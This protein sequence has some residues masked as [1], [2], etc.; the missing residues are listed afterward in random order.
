MNKKSIC[1]KFRII[2][3]NYMDN[4]LSADEARAVK[5]HLESCTECAREL[6]IRREIDAIGK[7]HVFSDPGKTFWSDQRKQISAA[8]AGEDDP[9]SSHG[10]N[11]GRRARTLFGSFGRRT[12][13]G[14]AA[15][16]ILILVITN[17]VYRDEPSYQREQPILQ[18]KPELN[19]NVVMPELSERPK[20]ASQ[21][22]E[23][24]QTV[25]QP[26]PS[27]AKV[28]QLQQEERQAMV[29]IKTKS[30][31]GVQR[32]TAGEPAARQKEI[33]AGERPLKTQQA[34]QSSGEHRQTRTFTV[35]E[36]RQSPLQ[37]PTI[38]SESAKLNM[39][40]ALKLPQT[41]NIAE[42][43]DD[44]FAVYMERQAEIR[45]LQD[46]VEQKNHWLEYFATVNTKE[47]R[48]LVVYDLY[49][50]YYTVVKKESPE[51]LKNEALN[52]FDHN[53]PTLIKI[54]GEKLYEQQLKYFRNML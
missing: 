23:N 33:V 39:V 35:L 53:R 20:N 2:L 17:E 51:T 26:V 27:E 31:S 16:A 15:A 29:T 47:I 19:K 10:P 11:T 42:N 5:Q 28:L 6:K 8:L 54:L 14:L 50:I 34:T 9:V 4:E 3:N 1:E 24:T 18:Q 22:G 45:T 48:D 36:K 40:P 52:F 44:E 7:A 25:M 38:S 43:V 46:L 12:A 37:P 49:E 13:I 30:E 32:E 41:K 21:P